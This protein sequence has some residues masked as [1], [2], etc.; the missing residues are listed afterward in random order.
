M[1]LLRRGDPMRAR[2]LAEEELGLSRAWGT[3]R[4]I[5]I[6]L[7]T[8]ALVAQGADSLDLLQTSVTTLEN[9]GAPLEL[10]RSLVELGS[11]L[12]RQKK[13][14]DAREPLAAGMEIAHRCG[15]KA[16]TQK[17]REELVMT[18]ARPR[19]PGRRGPAALTSAERRV[20]GLAAEG[21]TNREIAQSL[22]VTL[23]TVEVHLT[24]TYQKLGISSRENLR[25]S[26]AD[27]GD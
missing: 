17:A 7:R 21:M 26:L 14:N 9:S 15:A 19:R 20:A 1:V 11:V 10:A 27:Q 24:H 16:L 22:F 18:G 6:S 2:D 13:R 8:L 23:R 3:P 4:A 5:G 25:A 12:R